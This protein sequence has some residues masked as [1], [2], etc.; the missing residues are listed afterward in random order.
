MTGNISTVLNANCVLTTPVSTEFLKRKRLPGKLGRSLG[1]HT[2]WMTG[3]TDD[4]DQN[5]CR[6]SPS[7]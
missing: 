7:P 2:F 1:K 3:P 4:Q 5:R 6:I